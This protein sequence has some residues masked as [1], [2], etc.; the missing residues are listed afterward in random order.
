[1]GCIWPLDRSLAIPGLYSDK[2]QNNL[3]ES[4]ACSESTRTRTQ[5]HTS[6]PGEAADTQKKVKSAQAI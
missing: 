2:P 5:T 1:M 6:G 3:E 4:E